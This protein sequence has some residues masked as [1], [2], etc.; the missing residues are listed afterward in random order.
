MVGR[1]LGEWTAADI[2]QRLES[3]RV[4]VAS[5]NSYAEALADPQVAHRELIHAVDHPTAGLI[6]VVGPPWI[7]TGP[8]TSVGAPPLLGQH[9]DDVLANW[10]GWDTEKIELFKKARPL[11]QQTDASGKSR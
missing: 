6:R 11:D 3:E 9:T 4:P 10:L 5:V 8:E 7:M 2:T 1:R